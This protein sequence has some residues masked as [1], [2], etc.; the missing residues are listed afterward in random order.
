MNHF[1][2]VLFMALLPLAMGCSSE[3]TGTTDNLRLG[4]T[5]TPRTDPVTPRT[6]PVTPGSPGT[7][8]TPSTPADQPSAPTTDGPPTGRT[9]DLPPS[10]REESADELP[11][12]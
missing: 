5:D 8:T 1:F 7:R 6:D 3:G 10:V 2:A 12:I 4:V 9:G 11:E